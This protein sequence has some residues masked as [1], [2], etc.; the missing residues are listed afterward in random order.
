MDRGGNPEHR[1]RKEFIDP[2]PG[3]DWEQQWE[4]WELSITGHPPIPQFEPFTLALPIAQP[5][6]R[7]QATR[8]TNLVCLGPLRLRL[9]EAFL[10]DLR[11]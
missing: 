1:E 9:A 3:T 6:L 7:P 2:R 8:G 4:H 5:A 11:Y 10:E